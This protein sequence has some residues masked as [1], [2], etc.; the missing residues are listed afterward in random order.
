VGKAFSCLLLAVAAALV[1]PG[2]LSEPGSRIIA[3][4]GAM[5]LEGTSGGGIVPWALIAGYGSDTEWGGAAFHTRVSVDDFD[6]QSTGAAIGFRN[7][8]EISVAQQNIDVRPL[9]LSLGQDI[10]GAKVRLVGD[11]IYSP[12]PQISAGLQYKRQQDFAVPALLG[13]ADNSSTD[14]YLAASKL[15]LGGLAGYNLFANMTLRSTEANQGGLLGFGGPDGGRDWQFEAS[16]AAFFNY[17]WA[18]GIEFRQK[19]DLLGI[20][21]ED[22]RDAFV[23]WFPSK[24]FAVVAAYADLGN[25]AGLPDQSG[26]YLSVQVNQ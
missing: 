20:G 15:W 23:A 24:R 17:N 2:A 19:P 6:V 4:S 11:L 25:I 3:T 12:W 21:E 1:S 10:V 8:V 22:W 5:Q 14:Y 13:A 18:A 26:W 9:D 16:A 7:R